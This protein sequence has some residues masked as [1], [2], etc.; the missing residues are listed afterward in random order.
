MGPEAR[1]TRTT[2]PEKREPDM[3]TKTTKPGALLDQDDEM[4]RNA[5]Y[6]KGANLVWNAVYGSPQEAAAAKGLKH[7]NLEAAL[8]A[9]DALESTRTRPSCLTGTPSASAKP[10]SPRP[11]P[12]A[13]KATGNGD[14]RNTG[15]TWNAFASS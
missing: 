1:T 15:K 11:T 4:F 12:A 7:D 6:A 10:S 8:E 5:E 14:N 3:T 2:T 13:W 9:A